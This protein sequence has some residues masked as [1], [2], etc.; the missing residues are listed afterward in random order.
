[1][2]V[3]FHYAH[4]THSDDDFDKPGCYAGNNKER[5][6]TTESK[7]AYFPPKTRLFRNSKVGRFVLHFFEL[8]IPMVLGAVICYL[9]VRLI[10]SSS[11]FSTT[12][13]PGT[14]LF[15]LGDLLFLTVPVV[16]WMIFR[17]HGWQHSLEMS[18]AMIAP[19]AA[20]MVLGQL[21]AYDYLMWLLIAGYPIMCLGMIVYMLYRRDLF[22]GQAGI[23]A[24]LDCR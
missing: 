21:T 14:Y 18:V 12:Y 1:M 6:V 7:Q 5:S 24:A 10:T 16:V 19:V 23:L 9:V 20:V 2:A 13:Y 4:T 11:S 17:G 22:T 15:A 3:S 8:Q